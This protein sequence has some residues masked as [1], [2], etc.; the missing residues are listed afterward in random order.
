MVVL[1]LSDL[2]D[3]KGLMVVV[4]A[5]RAADCYGVNHLQ[6]LWFGNGNLGNLFV[7][8][9]ISIITRVYFLRDLIRRTGAM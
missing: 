8:T 1:E 2:V 6:G 3:P 9:R 5:H 4:G 7:L